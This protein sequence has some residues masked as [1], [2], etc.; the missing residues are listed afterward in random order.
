MDKSRDIIFGS[1]LGDTLSSHDI[2]IMEFEVPVIS[3]I[4]NETTL[5]RILFR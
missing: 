2:D 5:S 4:D 3:D 1:C